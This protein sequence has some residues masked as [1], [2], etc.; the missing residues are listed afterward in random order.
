MRCVSPFGWSAVSIHTDNDN[1]TCCADEVSFWCEGDS[2]V[3][4][5]FISTLVLH[6]QL[7]ATIF[8]GWRD[9]W[10]NWHLVVTRR[11]AWLTCLDL[12]LVTIRLNLVTSWRYRCHSR[13]VSGN[14]RNILVISKLNLSWKR[15]A[16]KVLIRCE[17]NLTC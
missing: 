14:N 4:G 12:T 15:S 2:S 6:C 11:K 5:Y 17:G 1:W 3:V 10:V 13:C 9:R 16:N 8:E 7:L